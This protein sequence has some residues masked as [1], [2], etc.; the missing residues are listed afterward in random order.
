[1]CI[2][3]IRRLNTKAMKRRDL[4]K[5]FKEAGWWVKRNSGHQIWTNGTDTEALSWEKEIPEYVAQK[6]IKRR[7]LK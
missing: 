6:I 2:L 5:M 3:D 7:G 4:E 1:V